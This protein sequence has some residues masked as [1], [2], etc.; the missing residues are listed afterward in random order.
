MRKDDAMIDQFRTFLQGKKTYLVAATG[1]LT[2]LIGFADGSAG[3]LAT[4]GGILAAIGFGSLR[5]AIA[6]LGA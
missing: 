5:A 3:L 2:A 4:V 1:V 6:R